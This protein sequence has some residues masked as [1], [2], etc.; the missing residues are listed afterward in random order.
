M[1]DTYSLS[2][3]SQHLGLINDMKKNNTLIAFGSSIRKERN[4]KG[5]TQDE[6]AHLC[7]LD[8]TYIGGIERGERNVSLININKIA[9]ALN[10]NI[11]DLF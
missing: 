1:N 3:Y 5:M 2:T 9:L 7:E 10:K 4:L 11:R 6:L 8:R